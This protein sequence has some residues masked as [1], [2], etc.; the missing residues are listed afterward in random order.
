[1]VIDYFKIYM[2][3]KNS[4]F[5]FGLDSPHKNAS[6]CLSYFSFLNS[7]KPQFGECFF[8]PLMDHARCQETAAKNGRRERERGWRRRRRLRHMPFEG[9][10]GT[11]GEMR[12]REKPTQERPTDPN[13]HSIPFLKREAHHPKIRK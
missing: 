9:W 2:K 13:P 12:Q 11:G 5:C 3:G 8:W 7:T 4:L 6:L 1:M 10:N